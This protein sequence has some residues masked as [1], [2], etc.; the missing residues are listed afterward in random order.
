MAATL[1]DDNEKSPGAKIKEV[2]LFPNE[3]PHR[4]ASR[5]IC[6]VISQKHLRFRKCDMG[7]IDWAAKVATFQKS[8][9]KGGPMLDSVPNIFSLSNDRL[10]SFSYLL[11]AGLR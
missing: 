5:P 11:I 6:Q 4:V 3:P 1:P 7:C 8:K 2:I 10:G 9:E